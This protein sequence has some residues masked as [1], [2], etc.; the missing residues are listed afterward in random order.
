MS[1]FNT[2]TLDWKEFY[3]QQG[4]LL[5]KLPNDICVAL[6]CVT[7]FGKQCFFWVSK[8]HIFFSMI[9][10]PLRTKSI[11]TSLLALFY[12]GEGGCRQDLIL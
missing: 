1:H 11:Q 5:A 8:T 10:G 12:K 3:I 9:F 7:L 6:T 4:K 2:N